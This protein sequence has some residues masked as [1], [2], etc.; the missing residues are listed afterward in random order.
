MFNLIVLGGLPFNLAKSSSFRT[1]INLLNTNVNLLL[2]KST[3]TIY[4][5]LV[6]TVRML[7]SIVIATFR[8]AK[9]KIHLI[10]NGWTFLNNWAFLGVKCQFVDLN[11]VLRIILLDLCRI[12]SAYTSRLTGTQSLLRM[13]RMREWISNV[14][15]NCTIS[16]SGFR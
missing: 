15:A 8:A 10:L 16:W 13:L 14:W 5:D 1:Y 6:I 12:F 7:K 3:R 11:G 9:S 4:K 2:F